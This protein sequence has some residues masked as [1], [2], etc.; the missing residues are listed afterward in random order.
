MFRKKLLWKLKYAKSLTYKDL[1]TLNG[2]TALGLVSPHV[3]LYPKETCGVS[4]GQ[5]TKWGEFFIQGKGELPTPRTKGRCT[6]HQDVFVASIPQHADLL[7]EI[8]NHLRPNVPGNYPL[9]K[10]AL[11]FYQGDPYT[12][13]RIDRTR[14]TEGNAGANKGYDPLKT[15]RAGPLNDV[16]N[17]CRGL[18]NQRG[19]LLLYAR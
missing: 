14:L 13:D 12:F 16:S 2:L 11:H 3:S 7:W 8:E 10:R 6:I 15:P 19:T 4:E 18:P 1:G 9:T 17:H 5:L